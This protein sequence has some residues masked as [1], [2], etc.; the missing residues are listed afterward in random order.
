[1]KLKYYDKFKKKSPEF[2]QNMCFQTDFI[3]Y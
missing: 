2:A 3:T 1:M